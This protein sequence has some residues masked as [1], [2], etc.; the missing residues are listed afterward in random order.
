MDERYSTIRGRCNGKNK[1]CEYQLNKGS[2]FTKV[3]YVWI[4]LS[5]PDKIILE[6]TSDFTLR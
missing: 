5:L 6:T 3:E 2:N 1:Y 4:I